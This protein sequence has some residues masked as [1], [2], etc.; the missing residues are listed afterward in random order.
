M[1]RMVRSFWCCGSSKANQRYRKDAITEDQSNGSS[2]SSEIRNGIQRTIKPSCLGYNLCEVWEI[3][4]HNQRAI[5]D[6]SY[7]SFSSARR[8]YE[9]RQV[10]KCGYKFG[11]HLDL[12]WI[13]IRPRTRSRANFNIKELSPQ[14]RE[15]WL[16]YRQDRRLLSGNLIIFKDLLAS[17]AVIHE[18]LLAQANS[19][20]DRNRFRSRDKP[21]TIT[22]VSNA[23]ESSKPKNIECPFEDGQQFIWTC[24][25]FK[26]IK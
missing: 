5:Q 2:K 14:L 26:S 10:C 17:K 16:Q 1:A 20:V 6:K 18:N 15:Q 21:K 25:K 19:S 23:E 11:E 3:G 4:C 13:H 24:D 7:P 22:F 12:T 9:H 8:F